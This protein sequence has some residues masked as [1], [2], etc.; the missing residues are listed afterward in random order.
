MERIPWCHER[1]L[2]PRN[3][4]RTSGE[5]APLMSE[6]AHKEQ[7]VEGARKRIRWNWTELG[8]GCPTMVV[9]ENQK[10]RAQ[11]GAV[12]KVLRSGF[13][14]GET[15]HHAKPSLACR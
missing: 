13:S 3:P 9:F 7:G 10:M 15:C 12:L 5:V 11:R 8:G 4:R 2:R 14:E 1:S 6:F